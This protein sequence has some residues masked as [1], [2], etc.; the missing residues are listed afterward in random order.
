MISEAIYILL[1]MNVY[2]DNVQKYKRDRNSQHKPILPENEA[3]TN[4]ASI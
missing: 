1:T 2:S 3:I 4:A